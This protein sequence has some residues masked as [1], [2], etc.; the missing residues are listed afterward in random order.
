MSVSFLLLLGS[1]ERNK[2]LTTYKLALREVRFHVEEI[3]GCKL[4]SLAIHA[5]VETQSSTTV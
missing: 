4:Q 2:R 3:P 5:E 1:C